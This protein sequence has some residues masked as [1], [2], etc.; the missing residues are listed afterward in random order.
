M[1]ERSLTTSDGRRRRRRATYFP[2]WYAPAAAGRLGQAAPAAAQRR[3][4][5]PVLGVGRRRTSARCWRPSA[6]SATRRSPRVRAP[7]AAVSAR[8]AASAAARRAAEAGAPA[9]ASETGR[10]S[11]AG[12]GRHRRKISRW[13]VEWPR[14]KSP[15]AIRP[16]RTIGAGRPSLPRI[17][18]RIKQLVVVVALDARPG[19]LQ[20]QQ[21]LES[22]EHSTGS[23]VVVR[24]RHWPPAAPAVRAATRRPSAAPS[25]ARQQSVSTSATSSA[26]P[27][28]RPLRRP[29]SLHTEAPTALSADWTTLQAHDSDFTFKFPPTWD[30][31]Y[32][33]FVFTTSSL[34]DPKRSPRRACRRPTR[35]GRTS[36]APRQRPPERQRPHRAGR[37]V[38]PETIFERQVKRFG[39]IT[40]VKIVDNGTDGLHRR[41]AGDGRVVH[42]QQGPDLPGELV[43]GPRRAAV[44]LPVAGAKG[45]G[46][47]RTS[48]A[49]CA[50]LAVVGQHPRR[51]AAPAAIRRGAE[52]GAERTQRGR[53]RSCWRASP[54]RS[55]PRPRP[56]TPRTSSPRSRRPRPR[57]TR[58]S[59]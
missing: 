12:R 54:R 17:F 28:G 14:G 26:A 59:R 6:R 47:R 39:A 27:T 56:P 30:K 11:V 8:A 38:G 43:H 19:R 35:R 5:R 52:R 7:A 23:R 31:L 10:S 4:R 40:D 2:T 1:L 3:A 25:S 57:S 58:C 34:V 29:A 49:R 48:S 37:H 20:Q 15:P 41:R 13:S 21:Q 24:D 46:A 45:P 55:I 22:P 42:V 32:G 9:A 44:R 51:H 36:C 18:V 16:S 53:P 33:A 50:D